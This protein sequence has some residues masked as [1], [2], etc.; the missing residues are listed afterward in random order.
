VRLARPEDRSR[1]LDVWERSVRATHA[2]LSETDMTS[3]TPLVA[4]ELGSDAI[5]WWV[6][7]SAR[8]VVGLLGVAGDS[9]EALFLD[10]DYRGRGG[11]KLLVEH[12]QRFAIGP[13]AVDVN[14]QND[15][16]KLFYERLGFVVVGRSPTDSGGRPFPI[17]HMKRLS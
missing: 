7:E 17:L 11:G 6:L 8:A 15:G 13:L 4:A 3:L 5:G 1:M 2:F 14:E 16:A 10:P 12:A 9:I